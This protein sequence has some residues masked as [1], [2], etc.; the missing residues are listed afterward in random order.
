MENL[1]G[2]PRH[3]L[4]WCLTISGTGHHIPCDGEAEPE[5]HAPP[6]HRG[7]TDACLVYQI[8]LPML[9]ARCPRLPVSS[10]LH[11]LHR[12][13]NSWS[14][15]VGEE[16]SSDL[17]LTLSSPLHRVIDLSP[18]PQMVLLHTVIMSQGWWPTTY[19][20]D[21]T[22]S[23]LIQAVLLGLKLQI[24]IPQKVTIAT[25]LKNKTKQKTSI[26]SLHNYMCHVLK[27][28]F[29]QGKLKVLSVK[30]VPNP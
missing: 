22:I 6:Q 16:I 29:A 25:Q 1:P 4:H 5:I 12:R 28:S 19:S 20:Q 3:S 2:T 15:S 23:N 18:I 24:L 14:L 27:H 21:F 7:S 9:S 30:Q 11:P 8:L 10:R 13:V 17:Y 26:K